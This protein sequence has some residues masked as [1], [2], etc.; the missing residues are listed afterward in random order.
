MSVKVLLVDADEL[1]QNLIASPFHEH[2]FDSLFV[3]KKYGF[4][5]RIRLY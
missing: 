2:G 3:E 4:A 1:P 5:V